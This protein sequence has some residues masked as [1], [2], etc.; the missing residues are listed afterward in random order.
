MKKLSQTKTV[1]RRRAKPTPRRRV[2]R[3]KLPKLNW[4]GLSWSKL[5]WKPF[6]GAFL[7]IFF[8]AWWV[9]YDPASWFRLNKIHVAGPT[10]HLTVEEIEELAAPTFGL[11]LMGI[12]LN[13]IQNRIE[14]HPWVRTA[15]LRRLLP[16]TLYILVEEHVPAA[17]LL[18][19]K[20]YLVSD[21]GITI[22][23]VEP[24]DPTDL[25]RILGLEQITDNHLMHRRI[26][27]SLAVAH[28]LKTTGAL[29]P[30]GLSEIKWV[31][32]R[33]LTL[34]TGTRPFNI[35]LGGAPW[36][37]KIDRLIHVLPHVERDGRFPVRVALDQSDGVVV[38]YINN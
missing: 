12:D 21:E 30:F 10:Q 23:K 16:G 25:P 26:L 5:Q 4:S 17:H 15:N 3:L 1:K 9:R 8:V 29:E 19:P 27:E 28:K 13:P 36:S 31:N 18:L 20:P 7:A 35:E 38:R 6:A 14:A 32:G 22:K 33:R 37:D 2:R 24:Q 11:P 34:I